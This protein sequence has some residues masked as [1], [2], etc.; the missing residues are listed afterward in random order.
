MTYLK[1]IFVTKK[2]D[3]S[4]LRPLGAG[5][6]MFITLLIAVI[7]NDTKIAT[8]GIM[9]AFSYLYFQYT[10]V[11]QNM[12]YI[13]YHGVSLYLAFT[14][15]IY[16]STYPAI[17]PFLI[18]IISFLC[19]LAA[20][21]FNVPK[22]DYFFILMLFATGTNLKA[23]SHIL[24][25]S[26]YLLYGIISALISGGIVSLLLKLPIKKISTLDPKLSLQ[27]RYYIMIYNDSDI[28]LK[29]IHFSSIIF[30][31]SYLATL[32][33]EQN[34]YWILITSVAI[35]SGEKIEAIRIRSHQRVIGSII[36]LALG[37][38]LLN[39]D[40][41]RIWVYLI[42]V[43]LNVC[44]VY[45]VPRNYAIANFF[46]NPQILLLSSLNTTSVN[47]SLIPYRLFST[48]IGVG[49]VL[50]LMYLFDYGLTISKRTF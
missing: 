11:K 27:D 31:S 46:T 5:L 30:C 16:A 20:K 7:L 19:F 36:G 33:N 50:I 43:I 35:L 29:A 14:I 39:L 13:A 23:T 37:I 9:G 38:F 41:S 2:I 4:F 22:P 10:S 28:I 12:V 49:I 3:D 25:T 17:I 18:S 15:G 47:I 32:F 1:N 48:I 24:Q 44:V 26:N 45:F 42:I 6:S 40:L 21:L 34:G 8:I